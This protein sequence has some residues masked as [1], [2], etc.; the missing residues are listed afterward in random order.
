MS[1]WRLDHDLVAGLG[2]HQRAPDRRIGRDA[3]DARDLDLHG[4]ALLV[5]DLHL[6]PD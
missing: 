4:R 2:A 6:R 1:P 5:L 3:A